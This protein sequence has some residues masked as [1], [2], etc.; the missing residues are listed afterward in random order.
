M[1]T[2]RTHKFKK[3]FS[4]KHVLRSLSVRSQYSERSKSLQDSTSFPPLFLDPTPPAQQTLLVLLTEGTVHE[5]EPNV[6]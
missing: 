1:Y 3:H 5:K 2:S 6:R 4:L